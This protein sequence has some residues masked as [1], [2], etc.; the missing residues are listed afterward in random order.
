TGRPVSVQPKIPKGKEISFLENSLSPCE[1]SE[2]YDIIILIKTSLKGKIQRER[3][4]SSWANQHFLG[5]VGAR[6]KYGFLIGSPNL[7]LEPQ[8]RTVVEEEIAR[9]GD[10]I[11]GDFKDG[12]RSLI[13]KA[14]MSLR[15]TQEF[16]P[17]YEFLL[18]IDDDFDLCLEPLVTFLRD[19]TDYPNS[20]YRSNNEV[21]SKLCRDGCKHFYG[22]YILPHYFTPDRDSTKKIF[23]T[24]EE[25][26]PDVFPLYVTGLM[27]MLSK[28]TATNMNQ[29][30]NFM[31]QVSIEDVYLGLLARKLNI[32]PFGINHLMTTGFNSIRYV[33][34]FWKSSEIAIG[35]TEHSFGCD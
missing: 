3:L 14:M 23:L 12:Y 26:P 31:P 16:C 25:Y 22:G 34:D 28:K 33:F 19:P 7:T 32:R 8:E 29:L 11:I 30:A 35:K 17:N 4:R 2:K 6:V 1:S 13:F 18:I 5:R 15:W 10:F 20:N 9:Y 21:Y 27:I 24:R